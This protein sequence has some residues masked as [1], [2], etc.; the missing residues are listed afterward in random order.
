MRPPVSYPVGL[1]DLILFADAAAELDAYKDHLQAKP[2]EQQRVVDMMKRMHLRVEQIAGQDGWM[3]YG[4][5]DADEERA[6]A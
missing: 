5:D 1:D 6:P 4:A 3:I 2:A